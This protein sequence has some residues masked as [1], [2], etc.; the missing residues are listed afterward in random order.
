MITCTTGYNNHVKMLLFFT[1]MNQCGVHVNWLG[2]LGTVG[3]AI[4]C[5][6]IMCSKMIY[7]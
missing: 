4:M 3:I 5:N 6:A 7:L 2:S 1:P